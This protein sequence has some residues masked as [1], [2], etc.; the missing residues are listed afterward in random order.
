M[1]KMIGS[2]PTI[3]N[4]GHRAISDIFQ[5]PVLIQEKVDGSQFSFGRIREHGAMADTVYFRSKGANVLPEAP[6]MFKPAVEAVL[7]VSTR[8]LPEHTYRGEF[9]SKPKHNALAYDRIPTNY[10]IIYD[11]QAPDGEFLNVELV[12]AEAHKLGFEVVPHIYSGLVENLDQF[13]GYLEAASILGG[14]KIEGVVVKNYH[15]FGV[16]KKPLF[17]KFVSQAYKEVHSKEWKNQNPGGRDI[18]EM[19]ASIYRSE[20]RWHKAIQHLRDAG[21]L[22][23]SPRDIGKLIAEVQK[24]V[25]KECKEEI[26][27]RLW[28]WGW[29][30]KLQR[31][32]GAGLAEWYKE[33]LLK[34]AFDTQPAPDTPYEEAPVLGPPG[35][36]V[37][38]LG[39]ESEGAQQED[40]APRSEDKVPSTAGG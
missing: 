3:F 26:M 29:K 28:A 4:L 31:K 23:M 16:D 2:Y 39:E 13:T 37:D 21:E 14:Q 25:E 34:Q 27:E 36:S 1:E 38:N 22:D 10:I 5:E 40:A 6:G 7:E 33:W 12:L 32:V 15:R 17:G 19:L 18:I 8:L 30:G 20:T 35:V 24:D 11:I 9:L